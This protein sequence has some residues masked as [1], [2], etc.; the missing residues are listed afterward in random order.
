MSK[1][2]TVVLPL[3]MSLGV[4]ITEVSKKITEWMESLEQPFKIETDKL[5]L[6]KCEK[7]ADEYS[8]QYSIMT[9][10]ELS[11]SDVKNSV[12][13]DRTSETY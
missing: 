7:G 9:R 2:I 10:K 5:Q 11:A 4:R 8:Y 13:P 3:K 1:T 12:G 6:V